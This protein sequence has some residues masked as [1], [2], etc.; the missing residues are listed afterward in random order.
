MKK[1]HQINHSPAVL[2]VLSGILFALMLVLNYLTPY[3]CDD[4]SYRLSFQTGAPLRSVLEIFPSM[5]AHSLYMN[6][7]LISHGLAQLFMLLP[8]L[9]FDVVNAAVFTGTI[10]AAYRLCNHG[11]KRSAL[12]FGAMFCLIWLFTPAFGQVALWQVGA[13]NY[14]WALSA[15]VLFF[16]PELIRFQSGRVLLNRGWKQVLFWLYAFLFGWYNEIASFVGICM[17]FCLVILDVWMNRAKLQASRLIPVVFAVLGFLTMLS[18]P[19]QSANKQAGSMTLDTL[20]LQI[21][22]CCRMLLHYMVPLLVL[23]V[24]LF[25]LGLL[26]R[27]PAR[28]LVLSGLFA[29]AG[30]CANFMPVAA[31]YYPERCMCTTALMLVMAI[32]FLA[33]PLSAREGTDFAVSGAA[34]ALLLVL[35]LISGLT[36][37]ADIFSC[38]RQHVQR[39]QTIAAALEDGQRDVTANVVIPQTSYSGYWQLRDL[40]D[41]PTT[42]PNHAMAI[43]YGLDSLIGE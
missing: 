26:R 2:A 31:S 41:D 15:C 29:L 14:F 19:A 22:S 43:Y 36:G 8:P 3:I 32:A 20:L 7:R 13:I 10:W 34:A 39:E 24:M 33:A 35:T 1:L 30:V 28:T 37:S 27:L 12:L 16:A 9:V 6:G 42:W 18:M 38:Y 23:F 4:F 21:A 17:V 5:A 11:Q 40:M 25:L